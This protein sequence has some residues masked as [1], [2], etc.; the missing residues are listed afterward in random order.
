MGS[1]RLDIGTVVNPKK[2]KWH[3]MPKMVADPCPI[4]NL[5]NSV[6]KCKTD[7]KM[8]FLMQTISTSLYA[9]LNYFVEPCYMGF[10]PELLAS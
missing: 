3:V 5:P 7:I 6:N 4:P 10:R 2:E 9:D 8:Y 1:Y